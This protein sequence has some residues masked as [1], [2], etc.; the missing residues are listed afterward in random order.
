MFDSKHISGTVITVQRISVEN[1]NQ[2][3]GYLYL[4][5]FTKENFILCRM[6]DFTNNICKFNQYMYFGIIHLIYS[7]SPC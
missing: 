5:K 2:P 1:M 6:N 7:P 4:F 3:T